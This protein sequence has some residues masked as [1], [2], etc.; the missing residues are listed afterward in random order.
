MARMLPFL[1][2]VGGGETKFQPVFVGDIAEAIA[3]AVD[4]RE[5]FG[6]TYEFGGPEV[7]SFREL[8]EYVLATT[9]RSRLLIPVPFALAK[10][11]ASF[12]QYLPNP[13]LTPD[14]VELL[15][16]DNVVSEHAIRENRTLAAFGIVPASYEAIVPNYLWRFRKSG[17]FRT[18]RFASMLV[19]LPGR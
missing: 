8:M 19:T 2:L 12:L 18:G 3:I 17:Q 9:E 16:H 5:G 14:Q 10:L 7:K 6:T 13:P 1:P 15:R 11:Q 4:K